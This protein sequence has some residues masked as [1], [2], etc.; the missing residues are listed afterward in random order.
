MTEYR[1][2]Q[3]EDFLAVADN[4]S[5]GAAARA[6]GKE[7]SAIS[8]S[9]RKLEAQ[10]GL[11]LFDR[12]G[13][14]AALTGAGLM[15][16][17]RAR[18]IAEELAAFRS[19]TA[20]LASGTEAQITVATDLI[21]PMAKFTGLFA[22]FRAQFPDVELRFRNLVMEDAARIL[23][24]GQAQLGILMLQSDESLGLERQ[25]V[26]TAELSMVVAASHPLAAIRGPVTPNDLREHLQLVPMMEPGGAILRDLGVF[27]GAPWRF[28]QLSAMLPMLKQGLGYTILPDAMIAAELEAGELVRLETPAWSAEAATYQVP[29]HVAWR[30]DAAMGP[31]ASWLLTK[32]RSFRVQG[33]EP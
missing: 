27:G 8:H 13:Y 12:S 17:P 14:R 1:W 32:L 19:H 33:G 11:T 28:E 3:V 25:L 26:T 6:A 16:L 20:N 15:I 9:I 7:P 5:F 30:G 4:G 31:A 29:V 22:E 24:E 18:R 23:L 2:E 21:F 10:T